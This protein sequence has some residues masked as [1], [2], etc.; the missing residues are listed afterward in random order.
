MKRQ[1]KKQHK[2]ALPETI[3]RDKKALLFLRRVNSF[4]QKIAVKFQK[5][6]SLKAGFRLTHLLRH[7]LRP[8]SAGLPRAL[9]QQN[10]FQKFIE[11]YHLYFLQ[12]RLF[13]NQKAASAK[14]Q[15]HSRNIR[16]HFHIHFLSRFES[17]KSYSSTF[18]TALLTDG[19]NFYAHKRAGKTIRVPDAGRNS[20]F[21]CFEHKTAPP[22]FLLRTNLPHFDK[23]YKSY[24]DNLNKIAV[25]KSGQ[26]LPKKYFIRSYSRPYTSFASGAAFMAGG[27]LPLSSFG[28]PR[29]AAGQTHAEVIA[30]TAG[31]LQK[32]SVQSTALNQPGGKSRANIL[33]RFEERFGAGSAGNFSTASKDH[34][35]ID[36]S[37]V[38]LDAD[39]IFPALPPGKRAVAATAQE[40]SSLFEQA[41]GKTTQNNDERRVKTLMREL[42]HHTG[43]ENSDNFAPHYES[44]VQKKLGRFSGRALNETS[45]VW[46]LHLTLAG[47]NLKYS[48]MP[49]KKELPETGTLFFSGESPVSTGFQSATSMS[50]PYDAPNKQLYG[51]QNSTGITPP[52]GAPGATHRR[53]ARRGTLHR[54]PLKHKEG[55]MGDLHQGELSSQRESLLK[56]KNSSENKSDVYEETVHSSQTS[57]QASEKSERAYLERNIDWITRKV[58]KGIE[59]MVKID[60]E[61][62]R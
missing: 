34:I 62:R 45:E 59:R 56:T 21:S 14:E 5:R 31:R 26:R 39:F 1:N 20:L 15:R 38:P 42:I 13:E 32:I 43:Q 3:D 18:E 50:S 27:P 58:Y 47:K 46:R 49:R 23:L 55:G 16:S 22:L 28:G 12:P 52:V 33:H 60:Y 40:I 4:V 11:R 54:P 6:N 57:T 19:A 44:I 9:Y 35:T 17:R 7:A 36:Q 51:R 29:Q 48:I 8:Q 24:A 53:A 25:K 41:P 37:K 10:I 30:R 61:R 2:T